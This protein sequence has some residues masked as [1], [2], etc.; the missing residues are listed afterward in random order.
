M[1]FIKRYPD[2]K[3]MVKLWGSIGGTVI[4]YAYPACR[5]IALLISDKIIARRHRRLTGRYRVPEP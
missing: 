2:C 5:G 3:T 4:W 1:F